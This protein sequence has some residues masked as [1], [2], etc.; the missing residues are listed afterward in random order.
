MYIEPN[1]LDWC[2]ISKFKETCK[3][4]N[5]MTEAQARILRGAL[6]EFECVHKPLNDYGRNDTFRMIVENVL[7]EPKNERRQKLKLLHDLID[8]LAKED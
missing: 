6:Y 5:I 2:K 8:D 1:L 4:G 3:A 7:K